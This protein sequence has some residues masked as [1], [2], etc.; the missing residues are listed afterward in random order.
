LLE[1][2]IKI[3]FVVLDLVPQGGI[4]VVNDIANSLANEGYNVHIYTSRKLAASLFSISTNV[5]MHYALNIKNKTISY[6]LF[7][8]I[9]PFSLSGDLIVC[10]FYYFR[11]SCKIAAYLRRTSY[12][13]FIQGIENFRTGFLSGILNFLC[14]K[15]LYDKNLLVS[16]RYLA[17]KVS[18]VIGRNVDYI[19]VGPSQIF[20]DHPLK[21]GLKKYDIIYFARREEFKRLDL[22]LELF[23]NDKFI[24][25]HLK[26][27]VV[28]QDMELSKNI[29]SMELPLCKVIIPND[30]KELIDIIDSS[31]IMFFTSEYEGLGLPPLECMLRKVPVVT[32]KTYPLTEY[33]SDSKFSILLIDNTISAINT[34]EKLLT[35]GNLYLEY[36]EL[37][38]KFVNK[39][40]S[41]DYPRDFLKCISHLIYEK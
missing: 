23:S 20:Y 40:F 25:K 34:F 9:L 3:S 11:L 12:C 14:N 32:Y 26:V 10:N 21:S 37:C 2:N 4:R 6:L 15:S 38:R 31:K 5:E 30:D 13:Y 17:N 19:G 18:D 33:F 35:P 36:G 8:L 7:P 29:A 27:V 41:N 24:E 39:E 28:T 1:N 22:F 16:N